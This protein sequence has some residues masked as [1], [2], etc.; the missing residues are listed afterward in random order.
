[1]PRS[2]V[3]HF[4]CSCDFQPFRSNLNVTWTCICFFSVCNYVS[5]VEFVNKLIFKWNVKS[6]KHQTCFR[7]FFRW[8]YLG[9]KLKTSSGIQTMIS[10]TKSHSLFQEVDFL[11]FTSHASTDNDNNDASRLNFHF[12]IVRNFTTF[13]LILSDRFN[14]KCSQLQTKLDWKRK[15]KL[16]I[17]FFLNVSESYFRRTHKSSRFVTL[18][19]RF[20]TGSQKDYFILRLVSSLQFDG[21]S[22]QSIKLLSSLRLQLTI[23]KKKLWYSSITLESDVSS[24]HHQSGKIVEAF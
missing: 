12:S 19:V 4:L 22:I 16:R 8:S 3:V 6:E 1:M 23:T 21:E 17:L 2:N 14:S 18:W 11:V 13:S 10:I 7:L 24:H 15:R 5:Q 9:C 20:G